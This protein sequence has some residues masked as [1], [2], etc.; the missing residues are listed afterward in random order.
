MSER[1]L[2]GR[3][4]LRP[5][6]RQLLID[7]QPASLGARAFDLLAT[8]VALRDRVVT[9][10]ELL[11]RVWA[12]LVVEENNIQ[13]QVS[14]LRKLLGPTAIATLPG[15]GYRFCL[16][17]EAGGLVAP[18]APSTVPPSPVAPAALPEP[19]RMPSLI[20][21]ETALA[22]LRARCA[23]ESLVTLVGPGGVGK[24][25][26]A[27][28]LAAERAREDPRAVAWVDLAAL[29]DAA[30]VPEAVAAALGL[31][32][33]GAPPLQALVTALRCESVLIVLDNAEHLIEA[34]AELALVL[35]RGT[36]GVCLLV[37]SQAPLRVEGEVVWRLDGL[38]LPPP[39]VDVEAARSHGAVALLCE[40]A[41]ALDRRFR[42][43]ADNLGAVLEICRRLDGLPLALQLA[44]A[45]VGS[46]GAQ[47]VAERLDAR[48]ALLKSAA[49]DAA[50]RHGSL[51][52]ALDWS[53]ELLAP[54]EQAVFRRLG[55]F[56]GGFSLDGAAEVASVDRRAEARLDRWDAID[57]LAALV[58]R[59]L[60]Q[61]SAA[62]P[63]RYA[64]AET[65]RA[66]ALE[67][68][69]AAG[70]AEVARDAHAA[71]VRRLFE[72]A[73]ED[74]LRLSDGDWLARY[75]GEIDNLRVALARLQDRLWA[76]PAD[77]D[78][79][80]ALV[81][82]FGAAAP[83]W[84]HL[85]LDAEARRWSEVAEPLLAA[86]GALP[87]PLAARAWRGI[88]WTWA[89][90]EPARS[91]AAA[92]EA[93][94]LYLELGDV[95][96]QFAQ[97][98]GEAGLY[99]G[100]DPRARAALDAALRLERVDWP[101]RERAWGQRARADVA[102]AEGRLAE[103]RAAR[104]AELAL[105]A[106][107]GDERG[108]LRAL[109]HL[110]D[111]ALAM[112][113]ALEAVRCGRE[114]LADP[115][116]QRPSS[117]RCTAQ[118]NLVHA[119]LVRGEVDAAAALAPQVAALARDFGL[120]WLAADDLAWLAALQ[121]RCEVAASLAGWADAAHGWRGEPRAAARAEAR[122]R[123]AV[124]IR[125]ALD[126]GRVDLL[127]QQGAAWPEATVVDRAGAAD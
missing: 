21:R 1:L 3:C 57:A 20:G 92:H 65:A 115:A 66:Y 102:R 80:Q 91:R 86:N 108:R 60:V 54:T 33:T 46:L 11:D 39:G 74:W 48:F 12:G 71:W 2:F 88:Q 63:P 96:G 110:A 7:G 49:R 13:V 53:W 38:T 22:E 105:R 37:T 52:A 124:L 100:P 55:V 98:A 72:P 51:Q 30:L 58:E 99:V 40:R 35:L 41:Q 62:D 117:T 34:V 42:L 6:E 69:K 14:T 10:D 36:A 122:A 27:Q 95:H 127:A 16:P 56:A 19:G 4:E 104:Q 67:R 5:D 89:A 90:V 17:V 25:R 50:P 93:A 59:S 78:A 116:L 61:A 76:D 24:T 114:L 112:G 26:L 119:L 31:V 113:D 44:A 47:A 29:S 121:G 23:V 106:E 85:A 111:L 83:L 101:A 103:S 8:L 68:L 43:H 109:A 45:R 125:A 70:E 97:L 28:Q 64:L 94:R 15:R 87:G 82:L 75:A 107:A 123:A 120:L 118:L 84:Q 126:A 81:A 32:A 9:K 79:Q 73:A 77:A 18:L